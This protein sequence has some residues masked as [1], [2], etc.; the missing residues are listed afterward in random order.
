VAVSEKTALRHQKWKREILEIIR[1]TPNAS[2]ITIK[3]QSG[4]SMDSTL[5]LVSEL[6][7]E[8]LVLSLGKS[9]DSHIG[10]KPTLLTIR[11]D[12]CFFIG[13]RF[14]TGGV[15]GACMDFGKHII[16]SVQT[17]LAAQPDAESMLCAIETCIHRVM[18]QL[19]DRQNR[20]RGIGIGSPGIIDLK[21][22]TVLRYAH[23]PDWKN[24]PLAKRINQHFGLPAY[25]EHGVKCTAR[26]LLSRPEHAG[27]RNM[28]FLQLGMGAHLCAVINGRIHA[29]SHYL[30]GEI[31]QIP[32][33]E[34]T[35]DHL[36]TAACKAPEDEEL[37][38]QTGEALGSILA[39]AAMLA[40]PEKIVLSGTICKGV[41]FQEA[42]CQRLKMLCL[43]EALQQT[44][45]IFLTPDPVLDAAGAAELAFQKQ[46]GM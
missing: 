12:G 3:R 18:E 37:Q 33:E 6:L 19:G 24:V 28:L 20:L 13:I 1:S 32:V 10:R 4:L 38:V 23:I 16:C 22:G 5:S 7:E 40:D 30:A 9:E 31:G 21:S 39:A 41:S 42:L 45:L 14:S 36:V 43:P 8:G 29:G 44:R 46:F 34:S 27:T 25:V 35:L 15:Y 2:R 17:P 26:A 11:D